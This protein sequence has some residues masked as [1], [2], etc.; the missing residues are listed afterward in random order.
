MTDETNGTNL[1]GVM[2][3][4]RK[5]LAIAEDSRGDPNECAAAARMAESLM[6]KFEIEHAEVLTEKIR[7]AGEEAFDT[8]DLGAGMDVKWKVSKASGWA[9]LLGVAVA[10]LYDCQARYGIRSDGGKT[11][12]FSGYKTDVEMCKYTYEF[13][14]ANMAAAS[15]AYT[16]DIAFGARA[17]GE[18]FRRGYI[19][20]VNSKLNELRREKQAEMQEA[21]SSRALVVVKAQAVAQHF[22]EVRYGS[23]KSTTRQGEAFEQGRSQGSKLDVGRRGIGS[24]SSN[25]TLR[26][27]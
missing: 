15:R 24:S 1:E 11:I 5:L 4:I 18:S 26:L 25:G 8:V 22:G 19:L 16:K 10:K 9:G 20:A 2:R 6:R 14:V 12:R 17:E 21:A 27:G 13:V 7:N 3:R 23:A